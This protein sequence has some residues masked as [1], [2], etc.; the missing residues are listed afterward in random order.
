MDIDGSTND[1][2]GKLR[3]HQTNRAGII[4]QS[5]YSIASFSPTLHNPILVLHTLFRFFSVL[6]VPPW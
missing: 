5:L 4:P 1:L 2:P 6:S 3:F